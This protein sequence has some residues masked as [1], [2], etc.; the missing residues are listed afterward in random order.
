MLFLSLF[1]SFAGVKFWVS[2][3]IA[4]PRLEEWPTPRDSQVQLYART[5]RQR[6]GLMQG[7]SKV[8][9]PALATL[10][11]QGESKAHALHGGIPLLPP[12]P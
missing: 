4:P 6:C 9:R 10:T 7:E 11:N 8:S 1:L 3:G 2:A 12:R 5:A